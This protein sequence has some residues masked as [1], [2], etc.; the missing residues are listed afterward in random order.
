MRGWRGSFQ[1]SHPR[2]IDVAIRD[3]RGLYG[4]VNL[5]MHLADSPWPDQFEPTL[6]FELPDHPLEAIVLR[7]R[8]TI[9]QITFPDSL[10][11]FRR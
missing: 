4:P 8:Y 10:R 1:F 9:E 11:R 2:G 7:D 5:N 6:I 3:P